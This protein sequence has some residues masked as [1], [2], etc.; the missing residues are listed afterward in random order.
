MKN[1][2]GLAIS[3]QDVLDLVGGAEEE[4]AFDLVDLHA[5]RELEPAH[6]ALAATR[7]CDLAGI[8]VAGATADRKL[9]RISTLL[10]PQRARPRVSRSVSL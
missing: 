8:V 2:G 4:G 1:F 6:E 9:G 7:L 3:P 10:I 5:G